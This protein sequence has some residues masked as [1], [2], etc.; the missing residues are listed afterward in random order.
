MK[1]KLLLVYYLTISALL[2]AQK[3][4]TIINETNFNSVFSKA[5]MGEF[6]GTIN[7]VLFVKNTDGLEVI[8]DFQGSKAQLKIENDL[9]EV[10]DVSTKKYSGQTTSGK[11]YINYNTYAYANE[12]FIKLNNDIY[13]IGLIDGACDLK[14]NGLSYYYK[15]EKEIEYLIM[16]VDKEL[17]LTNYF[18]LLKSVNYDDKKIEN[19]KEKEKLIKLLPNSTLIFAIKR[20]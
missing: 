18:S 6:N 1:Q 14:I 8:L 10:Y 13:Q 2:F 3:K 16:K 17:I 11:S 20:T 19:L 15:A 12:L 7:G 4:Q 5:K 9:D